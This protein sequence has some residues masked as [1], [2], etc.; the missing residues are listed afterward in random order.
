[1]Q[2]LSPCWFLMWPWNGPLQQSLFSESPNRG[3]SNL[4]R[5][6]G[7]RPNYFGGF[8]NR[9]QCKN[10]LLFRYACTTSVE[11]TKRSNIES[12]PISSL[13][14]CC[15]VTVLSCT[16]EFLSLSLCFETLNLA[17]N[18]SQSVHFSFI[19]STNRSFKNIS[20]IWNLAKT[21]HIP[22]TLIN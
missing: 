22:S 15:L 20:F 8:T 11:E 13:I 6:L 5:P 16:R 21:H 19:S 17:F 14:K 9:F 12:S 1:M 18:T 4:R 7:W 2:F 3:L 10:S